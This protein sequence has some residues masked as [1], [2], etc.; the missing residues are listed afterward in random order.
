MHPLNIRA[1]EIIISSEDIKSLFFLLIRRR[2]DGDM[3][4]HR[5]S[6]QHTHVTNPTKPKYASS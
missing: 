6:Y 4:S 3:M 1:D 5:F 2:D